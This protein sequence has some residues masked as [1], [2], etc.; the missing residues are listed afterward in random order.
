VHRNRTRPA[1]RRSGFTLI[2]ML[3][4]V[5]MIGML[6]ALVAPS[7]FRNVGASKQA[8]AR[9][10]IELLGAALDAYRLDND[11]YPT[12]AQGLESLRREPLSEPRPRNWRGPYVRKELPLDPWG[13][14]YVYRSPG[15]ANPW[16]YD[17]LSLGRDGR[18]GGEDEDADIVS[19][20]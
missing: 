2:E 8:A 13:R 1:A 11:M 5:L 14:P 7:V 9:S 19:W 3:V 17:L 12:T 18:E 6:A 4:V 16:S 15:E 10:Q 20:Q